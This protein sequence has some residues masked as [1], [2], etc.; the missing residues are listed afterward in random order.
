M[1]V[2]ASIS[3]AGLDEDDRYSRILTEPL[4][5]H[6]AGRATADHDI[7]CLGERRVTVVLMPKPSHRLTRLRM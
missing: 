4:G 1:D 6:T 7:V 3:F 2:R 5:D